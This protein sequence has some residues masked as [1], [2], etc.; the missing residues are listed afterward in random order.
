VPRI[1]LIRAF[2]IIELLIVVAIVALLVSLLTPALSR[3]RQQAA[4]TVCLSNLHQF[5]LAAQA[6]TQLHRDRYPIAQYTVK[7]IGRKIN[8][9]WDFITTLY[10]ATHTQ[11]VQPGL[12]WMGRTNPEIHQCPSFKGDAMSPGDPFTGY[13]YNT[14]YIGHGQ[15]EYTV[16]PIISTQVRLPPE[17]ALF[18]DGQYA[19]GAN[20]Y[21]RSPWKDVEGGGDDLDFRTAGTQGYRHLGRTNVAFCDGHAVAWNRCCTD[22]SEG[23]EPA[24]DTGFLS[25]DNRP[26]DPRAR[27]YRP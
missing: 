8:Y 14:S 4:G 3:A 13:N 9:K 24:S 22:N 6:Y 5:V 1:L 10:T 21:M 11:T 20:K 23:K 15:G 7:P 12:L 19:D 27:A 18:G 25:T 2:T 26:Y 16:A 17:C